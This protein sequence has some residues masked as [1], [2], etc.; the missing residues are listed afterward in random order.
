ML[1]KLLNDI[2]QKRLITASNSLFVNLEL[3]AKFVCF[4]S[5]I[6]FETRSLAGKNQGFGSFFG[7]DTIFWDLDLVS[8]PYAHKGYFIVIVVSFVFVK[9]FL[10]L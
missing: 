6:P 2:M 1:T 7:I 5:C 3:F 9:L 8:G 4:R 10:Q